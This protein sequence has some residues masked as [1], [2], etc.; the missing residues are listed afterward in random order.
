MFAKLVFAFSL[1]LAFAVLAN[2]AALEEKR[3]CECNF[4]SCQ[5][6]VRFV[7]KEI[8]GN[9]INGITSDAGSIFNEGTSL[10]ELSHTTSPPLKSLGSHRVFLQRV[11]SS[12]MRHPSLAVLPPT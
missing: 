10:G 7:T 12:L 4:S 1:I 5:L 2:A 6:R 11:Q 8:V 3:D 9:V